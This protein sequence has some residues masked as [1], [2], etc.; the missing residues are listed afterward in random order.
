MTTTTASALDAIARALDSFPHLTPE[1]RAEIFHAIETAPDEDV[2]PEYAFRGTEAATDAYDA[3][4]ISPAG[5]AWHRIRDY[6]L[7][8]PSYSPFPHYVT[9]DEASGWAPAPTKLDLLHALARGERM[10]A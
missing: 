2:L 10:T 8:P 7:A 9:L 3:Y 5:R 1:Q 6:K 4:L